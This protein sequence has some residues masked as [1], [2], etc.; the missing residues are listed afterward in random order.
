MKRELLLSL[1][2]HVKEA[3]RTERGELPLS[4]EYIHY[5]SDP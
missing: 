5:V 1:K 2:G 4:K 3:E